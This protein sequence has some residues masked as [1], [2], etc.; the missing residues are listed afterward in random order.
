MDTGL[1][2]YGSGCPSWLCRLGTAQS[3][4]LGGKAAAVF[5]EF[6]CSEK[7]PFS[8]W[9]KGLYVQATTGP[10]PGSPRSVAQTA[11]SIYPTALSNN[12]MFYSP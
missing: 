2:K 5:V 10:T 7:A 11:S 12:V 1:L 3:T 4:Q 9:Y 8:N 6:T